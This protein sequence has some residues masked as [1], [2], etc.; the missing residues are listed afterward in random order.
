MRTGVNRIERMRKEKRLLLWYIEDKVEFH[1]N[2]SLS[3][4]NFS[5]FFIFETLNDFNFSSFLK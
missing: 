5:Y 2:I 3:Y 4:K 1:A